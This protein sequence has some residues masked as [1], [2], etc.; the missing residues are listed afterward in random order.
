MKLENEKCSNSLVCAIRGVVNALKT[1]KNLRIDFIIAICIIAFSFAVKISFFEW[2][3]CLVSIGLML[4]AELFNTAIEYFVD[5]YTREKNEMAGKIKDISAGAVLILSL[6]IA[7]VG[8]I[9]FLPK[10]YGIIL[11]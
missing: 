6:N 10:I 9:I 7:I 1:E 5:M 3:V 2:M 4:S 8:I 11:G